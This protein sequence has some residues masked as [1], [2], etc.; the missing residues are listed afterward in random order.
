MEALEDLPAYSVA[1]FGPVSAASP[2]RHKRLPP[3]LE[4]LEYAFFDFQLKTYVD[5]T[6]WIDQW[7]KT[8]EGKDKIFLS[9]LR[10]LLLVA[11]TREEASPSHQVSS[12]IR[13]W[14]Y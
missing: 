13:I 4:Y 2:G 11:R 10:L 9:W 7:E 8:E 1:R 12:R 5:S 14:T 3:R 6:A